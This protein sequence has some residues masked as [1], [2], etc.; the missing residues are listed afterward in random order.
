MVGVMGSEL[1][2]GTSVLITRGLS[3]L[4]RGLSGLKRGL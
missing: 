4:R 2:N 1:N 3:G